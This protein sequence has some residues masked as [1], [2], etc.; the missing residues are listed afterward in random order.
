MT[1]ASAVVPAVPPAPKW[2]RTRFRNWSVNFQQMARKQPHVK[3]A[4]VENK[5]TEM[6]YRQAI[7]IPPAGE[8]ATDIVADKVMASLTGRPVLINYDAVGFT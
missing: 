7:C 1:P 5:L 4:P 8:K 2:K 3:T 6:L